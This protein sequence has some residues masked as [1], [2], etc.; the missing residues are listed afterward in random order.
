MD[1]ILIYFIR[2]FLF[3]LVSTIC[4]QNSEYSSLT[5]H[6]NIFQNKFSSNKFEDIRNIAIFN[7][8]ESINYILLGASIILFISAINIIASGYC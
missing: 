5:F 7:L 1:I 6:R 4:S 3:N 2:Q 8:P